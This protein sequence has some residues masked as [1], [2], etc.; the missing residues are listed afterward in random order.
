MLFKKKNEFRPDKTHSGAFSKLYITK[1]QR[2]SLLKWL[3]MA[4]IL[5]FL[6]VLQDTIFCRIRLLGATTDLLCGAL[7]MVCILLDPEQ[8]CIFILTGSCLYCFSGSAPGPYVIALLTLIGL[9]ISIFRQSYLHRTFSTTMLCTGV[10]I[11]LYEL[12]LFAIGALLGNTSVRRIG[13]FALSGIYTLAVMPVLYPIFRVIGKI[14][15][16]TWKD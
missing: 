13:V 3:L 15:G 1:K 2:L 11:M 10:A 6:S 12:L 14:G 16:E 5:V 7:L 4:L 9:M 8:G